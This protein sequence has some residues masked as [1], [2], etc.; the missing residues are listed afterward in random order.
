MVALTLV[1]HFSV[2]SGLTDRHI[3]DGTLS[4]TGVRDDAG[5]LLSC[6][7]VLLSSTF[8]FAFYQPS[9]LL[10]QKHGTNRCALLLAVPAA[11]LDVISSVS[12]QIYTVKSHRDEGIPV[13]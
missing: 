8:G 11:R 9:L 7:V 2:C 4:P 3:L 13:G 5:I 12:A 10:L 1:E 6:F